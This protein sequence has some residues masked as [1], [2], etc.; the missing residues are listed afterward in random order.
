MANISDLTSI[1]QFS[2]GLSVV[3]PFLWKVNRE[4]TYEVYVLFIDLRLFDKPEGIPPFKLF[5]KSFDQHYLIKLRKLRIAIQF[6]VF[7]FTVISFVILLFAAINSAIK[8]DDYIV[9]IYAVMT[10]I[11]LP[12][13]VWLGC[14]YD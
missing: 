4:K 11:I 8:I 7:I 2:L 6:L 1:A 13:A 9:V 12:F 5:L 10:I 14:A 3:L